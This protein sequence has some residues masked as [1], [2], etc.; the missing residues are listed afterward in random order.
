MRGSIF[1]VLV[2]KF[3]RRQTLGL[4]EI[5]LKFLECYFFNYS[6]SVIVRSYIHVTTSPRSLPDAARI[7]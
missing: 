4:S 6:S 3:L 7:V 5:L 1:L 2:T